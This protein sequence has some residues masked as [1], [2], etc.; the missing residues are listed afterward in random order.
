MEENIKELEKDRNDLIS[1]IKKCQEMFFLTEDEAKR[2]A[3][4]ISISKSLLRSWNNILKSFYAAENTKKL[5]ENMNLILNKN[6]IK[7]VNKVELANTISSIIENNNH[8]I[9]IE[10]IK[11]INIIK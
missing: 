7:V 10:K 1:S 2:M 11:S 4:K 3:E 5:I 9:D 6:Y 8:V